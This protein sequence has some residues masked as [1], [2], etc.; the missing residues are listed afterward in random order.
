MGE[1]RL[2]CEQ[3]P[4]RV[5]TG[6]LYGFIPYE[7]IVSINGLDGK[8]QFI[9]YSYNY[10][11]NVTSGVLSRVFYE[12]LTDITYTLSYDY[13]EVVDVTIKS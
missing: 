13:G 3:L 6:D 12:E 4:R 2:R 10:K 7:T 9:E 11:T 5:F 1:E 8:Y